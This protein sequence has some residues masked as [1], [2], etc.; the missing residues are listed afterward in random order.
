MQPILKIDLTAQ[1]IS[2]FTLPEEWIRD[3]LGGASL[4]ARLLYDEITPGLDPL[5]KEAVLLFLNGPLSGTNGPTTGRTVVCAK[6]PATGLWAESNIG[7]FWGTELRKAGYSGLWLVGA[8]ESP[9][10]VDIHDERVEILSAEGLWGLDTYQVQ[11][12]VG[13]LVGRKSVKV[14]GIGI[15]GENQV[16]CACI[17]SDHGRVAGRTGLGAVMG[18]KNLK[19]IAITGTGKVPVKNFN[20][21]RKLRGQVN[22]ELRSNIYTQTVR[23]MGTAAASDY[24]DYL[25]SFPKKGFTKG[26]MPGTENFSGALLAEK[27]LVGVKACHGCVVACGR[28]VQVNGGEKQKGPEYETLVGF[29]PNL[30]IDDPEFTFRMSELCDKFGMDTISVSNAI[31][32]A[33]RLY[34][35]SLISENETGGL[36]LEWGN[37]EAVEELVHQVASKNGFGTIVGKGAK[38]LEESYGNPGM[39][40]QVNGLEMAYHDPRG[41]SGMALVYT[42]SPRGACHN[43]SD[44]FL[45]EI[46]QAEET[47]GM[48]FYDRHAGAEKAGNVAIH[49]NWRA[50]TNSVIMCIFGNVSPQDL[51]DLVSVACDR[52][53]T[54]EECLKIGERGWNLKRVINNRLGL[55]RENDKLPKSL[56]DPLPDGG[57]ADYKIDLEGMLQAYYQARE[58][59]WETGYPSEEKLTTL[60]LGFVIPDLYP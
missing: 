23:E 4:A 32:F 7:G 44:Y 45:V 46:G 37:R 27:Y 31:G 22:R 41:L 49:Q 6:S 16:N 20:E 54:I 11:E 53:F 24:F 26:V 35:D 50:F 2:D 48:R 51:V 33:M 13:D 25:G 38:A 29:G 21:Y 56:L 34:E 39:A 5:S 30:W 14:A 1:Q 52:E 3:Y 58:W 57:A 59:D 10:I 36:I 19:A 8:A 60:G 42:T 40:A 47:L 12:A 43:Q 28:E 9:V 17:L 55:S 18:S 15:A